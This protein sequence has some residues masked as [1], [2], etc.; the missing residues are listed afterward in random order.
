LFFSHFD[1]LAYVLLIHHFLR[2]GIDHCYSFYVIIVFFNVFAICGR[3][4]RYM[5]YSKIILDYV[6]HRKRPPQVFI[7]ILA[8]DLYGT[9]TLSPSTEKLKQTIERVY[10]FVPSEARGSIFAVEQWIDEKI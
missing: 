4:N 2:V 10:T 8:N 6:R 5:D 7:A 3:Y 9:V 1:L